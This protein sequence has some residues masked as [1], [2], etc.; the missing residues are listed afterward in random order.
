MSIGSS[1]DMQDIATIA[2]GDKA[3]IAVGFVENAETWSDLVAR[4][5]F[6][7]LPQTFAYGEG[8][9]AKGWTVRRAVFRENGRIIAFATVLERRIAGIRIVTRINRG[10]IFLE[11]NPAA[12]QI[13]N[14]YSALRRRWRGPLL[15][16]PA[17]AFGPES[18]AQLRAASFRVRRDSGWLSG[19]VDLR[20][21][22][23][24]LWAH[25]ASNF[26]NH[27]RNSEKAGAELRIGDDAETF[28][29]ML[30][31]HVDNMH[32][33]H[34]NA[35]DVTLLRAM[36][37]AAPENLTV[38]QLVHDGRPVAGLSVA[39][40]ADTAE[41]HIA[42]FGPEG[43]RLNAG[44]FLM[45]SAMREMQRRGAAT[46]DVGGLLHTDD[47]F[48]RFKRTMRPVEFELAGEWMSF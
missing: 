32:D 22:E 47:G 39:R 17:L 4:A 26:R 27:V 1:E 11:A 40:F 19:R 23:E 45:W 6:P 33:K 31:R 44:N 43:R 28:E 36:R 18:S 10:P 35:V 15:I 24:A 38:F 3:A 48:T 14:V 46:F 2:H 13:I 41:A 9:R 25:V 5:P 8:K 34:F 29:W 30:A 12:E 42:W 20:S 37:A 7:H 16:A 21:G